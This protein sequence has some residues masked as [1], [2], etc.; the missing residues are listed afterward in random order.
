MSC[1]LFGT[2]LA[3]SKNH[4]TASYCWGTV[5]V[6]NNYPPNTRTREILARPRVSSHKILLAL[7]NTSSPYAVAV[8]VEHGSCSHEL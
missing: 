1:S 2:S 5:N 4:F 8:V 7:G 6:P 3:S